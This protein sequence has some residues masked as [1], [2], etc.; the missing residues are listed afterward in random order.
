MRHRLI[1]SPLVSSLLVSSIFVALLVG[2][3][4]AP[5]GA[6]ILT[7]DGTAFP[8]EPV[9][10]SDPL[11]GATIDDGYGDRVTTLTQ[12]SGAFVYGVGVEGF[13]PNVVARY[14]S[15]PGANLGVWRFDYGDLVRVLFANNGGIIQLQLFA[16]PDFDVQLYGFDLGGWNRTDYTI[17][18]VT[19]SEI[20]G[21][22]TVLDSQTNVAVEGDGTGPGHSTFGFAPLQAHFL[23]ITIDASNLDPDFVIG[24]DN[25]R[26]GQV[27]RESPAVETPAPPALLAVLGGLALLP[28]I[29]RRRWSV[30]AG[31]SR[32]GPR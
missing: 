11:E 28:L 29:G 24:M 16:D 22:D 19:I 1:S 13:T 15:I 3:F 9:G 17:N 20:F 12:N 21:P 14:D 18:S 4:A 25:I 26:F 8:N 7:F 2:A 10:N 32:R 6:T 5:A 31:S 30:V 27:Q 23:Q